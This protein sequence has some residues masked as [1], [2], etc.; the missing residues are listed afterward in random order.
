MGVEA[1]RRQSHRLLVFCIITS[2]VIHALICLAISFPVPVRDRFVTKTSTLPDNPTGIRISGIVVA[3]QM[4]Q[5]ESAEAATEEAEEVVAEVA[6]LVPEEPP[7]APTTGPLDPSPTLD[8]ERPRTADMAPA[9]A[10]RG[11]FANP[12]LWRNV[13]G[14]FP[15]SAFTRVGPMSVRAGRG[16]ESKTTPTD[17]WAFATWTTQDAEGRLWGAGPGL[18][19]LGGIVIPT[20]SERFDASNCGF[21]L[22]A[23][24]RGEYQFFLRAWLEIERQKQ[25]GIIA[26]RARAMRERREALRDTVPWSNEP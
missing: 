26:E 12:L 6:E 14:A 16:G 3:E 17:P 24:R 25:R 1:R 23:E 4:T 19:Y 9:A 5:L 11:R 15:D 18:I 13:R 8:L 20:C 2:A 10:L 21:G 22:P 7:P